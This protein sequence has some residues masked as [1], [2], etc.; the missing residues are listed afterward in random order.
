MKKIWKVTQT[1]AAV[2]GVVRCLLEVSKTIIDFIHM[3]GA[4]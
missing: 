3:F 4:K 2:I 1:V